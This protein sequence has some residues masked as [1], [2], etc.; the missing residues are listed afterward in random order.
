MKG[1]AVCT[2]ILRCRQWAALLSVRLLVLGGCAEVKYT[3]R[4]EP[5]V[6]TSGAVKVWPAAPETPALPIRGIVVG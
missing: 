4:L 6:H 5:E 1:A 2:H 3:M